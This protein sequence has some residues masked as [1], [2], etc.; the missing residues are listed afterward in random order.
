ML[1]ADPKEAP[2]SPTKRPR[3]QHRARLRV[4][5]VTVA[6]A[7]VVLLIVGLTDTLLTQ[8]RLH[9]A[10]VHLAQTRAAEALTQRRIEAADRSLQSVIAT[11]ESDLGTNTQL[12][13]QLNSAQAQL[14]QAYRGHLLENLN[15]A[16]ATACL[17]GVRSAVGALQVGNRTAALSALQSTAEPCGLIQG[18]AS[19]GG[20][21]F[22]YD[23]PDPQVIDA[24][25]TYCRMGPTRPAA[26]SR[27][28]S[29]PTSCNGAW[30]ATPCPGSL[31][32]RS[33]TT[34]GRRA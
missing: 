22:P 33:P 28:S 11:K 2:A 19:P 4:L 14:A 24:G 3:A 25:G 23:F 10:Q 26:T 18:V 20:P 6:L 30:S 29:R 27:S 31:P 32:G 8:V 13:A 5:P 17:A 16:A 1:V 7:S 34:P 12:R 9:H 21:V 15:V